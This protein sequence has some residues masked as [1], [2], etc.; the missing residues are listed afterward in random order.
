M[1]ALRLRES[2]AVKETAVGKLERE[3]TVRDIKE[4]RSSYK[5]HRE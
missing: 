5:C 3:E 4:V 1:L 2:K